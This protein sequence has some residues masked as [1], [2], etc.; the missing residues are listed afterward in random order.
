MSGSAYQPRPVASEHLV[1]DLIQPGHPWHGVIWQNPARVSGAPC[2]YGTRVP[3]QNLFDFLE[4]GKGFDEFVDSFPP[5]SRG[6]CVAVL[7]L[8]RVQLLRESQ[9]A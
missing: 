4:D 9:A 7:E 8:A 6:H 3:V 5:I 1:G 2:F